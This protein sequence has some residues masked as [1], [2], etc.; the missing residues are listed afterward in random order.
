MTFPS[1][2]GTSSKNVQNRFQLA[3]EY[4]NL[5]FCEHVQEPVNGNW[6]VYSKTWTFWP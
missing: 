5:H 2:A 3:F 4:V 6:N 1:G